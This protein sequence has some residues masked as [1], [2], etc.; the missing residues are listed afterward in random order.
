MISFQ[1]RK[2]IIII[3][4]SISFIFIIVGQGKR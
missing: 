4:S 2:V 3:S 1:S